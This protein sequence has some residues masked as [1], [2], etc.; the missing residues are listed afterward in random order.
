M[1]YVL[2]YRNTLTIAVLATAGA[3]LTSTAAGFAFA[4]CDSLA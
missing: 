3:T 2:Y 1:N 4:A